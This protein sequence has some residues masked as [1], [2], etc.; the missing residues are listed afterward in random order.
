[1]IERICNGSVIQFEMESITTECCKGDSGVKT[2]YENI[3]ACKQGFKYMFVNNDGAIEQK[4]QVGFLYADDVCQTASN[5]QYR[6]VND[7]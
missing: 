5:D 4:S 6:P 7:F 2:G 3:A 1:M